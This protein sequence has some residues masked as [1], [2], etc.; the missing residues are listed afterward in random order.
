[1][2]QGEA[3]RQDDHQHTLRRVK[4][5]HRHV[6][7]TEAPG[8]F[9]CRRDIAVPAAFDLHWRGRILNLAESQRTGPLAPAISGLQAAVGTVRRAC[10]GAGSAPQR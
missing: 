8:A 10:S 6:E 4:Q 7:A 1:M 3:R 5:T 9:G 2:R